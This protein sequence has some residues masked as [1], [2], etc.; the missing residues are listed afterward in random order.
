MAGIPKIVNVLI[1]NGANVRAVDNNGATPLHLAV[2]HDSQ[3][4]NSVIDLLIAN[5]ANVNA[6]DEYNATPLSE[7]YASGNFFY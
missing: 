7:A 2:R 4:H 5:G 6:K 3:E 1:K